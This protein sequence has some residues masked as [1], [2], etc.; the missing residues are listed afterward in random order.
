MSI[1][2]SY[3]PGSTEHLTEASNDQLDSR[4]RE[5]ENELA[6]KG[7]PG[8]KPYGKHYWDRIERELSHIKYELS[9]RIPDEE[10]IR[11]FQLALAKI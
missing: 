1:N 9:Q 5:I 8:I 4:I 3:V 7:K 2:S 11:Q 10:V 6:K